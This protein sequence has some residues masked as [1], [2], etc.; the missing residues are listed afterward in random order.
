MNIS[1]IKEDVYYPWF[2]STCTIIRPVFIFS[3]LAALY[4]RCWRSNDCQFG[5]CCVAPES[6]F[7]RTLPS[8]DF[9]YLGWWRP[10]T[11]KDKGNLSSQLNLYWAVL[12]PTKHKVCMITAYELFTRGLFCSDL[13]LNSTTRSCG[14]SFL[15][16]FMF[17]N[18][19]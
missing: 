9:F 2:Y 17:P 4:K 11:P 18:C 3:V 19:Q 14:V 1:E 5:E 8:H 10:L 13:G 16:Q 15:T 6:R 7:K 12:G